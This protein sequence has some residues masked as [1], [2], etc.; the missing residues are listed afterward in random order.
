[1]GCSINIR[2]EMLSMA[3]FC[4]AIVDSL[5]DFCEGKPHANLWI[6]V[7]G[8]INFLAYFPERSLKQ[9]KGDMFDLPKYGFRGEIHNLTYEQLVA[10]DRYFEEHKAEF[11]RTKKN[12][13][14]VLNLNLSTQKRKKAA[15]DC[16]DF[17]SGLQG[18]YLWYFD[19]PP[20]FGPP[21]GLSELVQKSKQK[22]AQRKARR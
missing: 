13:P 4:Q 16:L 17:F 15:E 8:A 2:A 9:K 7:K 6:R 22:S 1:M 18:K 20:N 3:I 14:M 5:I 12:L 10:A 11:F 19:F 21:R